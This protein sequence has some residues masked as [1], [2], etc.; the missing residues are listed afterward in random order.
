MKSL[1][2]WDHPPPD[3]SEH[4]RLQARQAGT[5]FTNPGG[6]EGWVDVGDQL[7]TEV[8]YP[9]TNPAVHGRELYL[10]PVDHN[11]DALTTTLSSHHITYLTVI[12]STV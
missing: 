11:A 3:T 8:V 9:H 7:R 2:T 12:Y 10:Q 4:T 1:A 5:S 6:I